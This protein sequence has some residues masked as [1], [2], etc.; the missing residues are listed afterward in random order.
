V[1]VKWGEAYFC[2]SERKLQLR[3]LRCFAVLFPSCLLNRRASYDSTVCGGRRACMCFVCIR[4][5][6]SNSER[7]CVLIAR[8]AM[9]RLRVCVRACA[10]ERI[11]C[12][13]SVL[14]CR[15]NYASTVCV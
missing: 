2:V 13:C 14:N 9:T 10:C 7:L 5:R 3:V 8:A 15:G 1:C 4:E 11:M 6:E 12:R